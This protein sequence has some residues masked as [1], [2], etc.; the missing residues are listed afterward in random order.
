MSFER[1]TVRD[2]GFAGVCKRR[3][4]FWLLRVE[5]LVNNLLQKLLY[6]ISI[7]TGNYFNNNSLNRYNL[8]S[9]QF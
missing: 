9:G 4:L 5:L 2:H 7:V 6:F 1:R 3:D 8:N